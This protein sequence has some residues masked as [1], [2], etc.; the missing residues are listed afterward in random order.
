MSKFVG[1][2]IESEWCQN[3][4]ICSE[5]FI[6]DVVFNKDEKVVSTQFRFQHIMTYVDDDYT[7]TLVQ[8]IEVSDT[9]VTR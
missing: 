4:E 8:T 7:R 3:Y 1:I 2:K 5:Q 9:F 6:G